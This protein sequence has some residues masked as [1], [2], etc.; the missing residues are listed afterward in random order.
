MSI[1][2]LTGTINNDKYS[3]KVWRG[4]DLLYY[5]LSHFLHFFLG[6]L[7]SSVKLIVN[8]SFP[9]WLG[10]YF[11]C[12]LW[13]TGMHKSKL[14]NTHTLLTFLIMP[15]HFFW[16]CDEISFQTLEYRD[17]YLQEE[18]PHIRWGSVG[19]WRD[20]WLP[21]ARGLTTEAF[22]LE[23]DFLT[24]WNNTHKDDK[25]SSRFPAVLKSNI[26]RKFC[27]F[28]MITVQ[29]DISF[30]NLNLWHLL[31]CIYTTV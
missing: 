22:W 25:S 2:L 1:K 31:K 10:N 12:G 4:Y 5:T 3:I 28:S 21:P 18:G 27:R 15:K 24:N 17:A 6:S 11:H 20:R 29:T 26:D 30:Q 9:A 13:Q 16:D 14:L 7:S 19:P 23:I 8:P